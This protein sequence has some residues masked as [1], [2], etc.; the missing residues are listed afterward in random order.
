MAS[1]HVPLFLLA[2]VCCL[3]AALSQNDSSWYYVSEWYCEEEC[4]GG[5][6]SPVR[7]GEPGLWC[8]FTALGY[9]SS[10]N[11]SDT[12]GVM[13]P[14]VGIVM[15]MDSQTNGGV[16]VSP[17]REVGEEDDYLPVE[18]IDVYDTICWILSSTVVNTSEVATETR[19]NMTLCV[20]PVLVSVYDQGQKADLA[21]FSTLNVTYYS[22][23]LDTGDVNVLWDDLVWNGTYEE[24]GVDCEEWRIDIILMVIATF[25]ALFVPFL[26]YWFC[27]P[28]V[29]VRDILPAVPNFPSDTSCV[30]VWWG[31]LIDKLSLALT[32]SY[33]WGSFTYLLAA[34]L[35]VWNR[36]APDFFLEH[37]GF[38]NVF[39]VFAAGLCT[40][41]VF[42]LQPVQLAVLWCAC[43][44]LV[45]DVISAAF[46]HMGYDKSPD[47]PS[48]AAEVECYTNTWGSVGF[49]VSAVMYMWYDYDN[50][51]YTTTLFELGMYGTCSAHM[52]LLCMSSM[53]V[54]SLFQCS[55]CLK[56]SRVAG[57][58]PMIGTKGKTR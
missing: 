28:A 23:M 18:F 39:Y 51:S 19:V 2:A 11:S 48:F 5:Y 33:M 37:E 56:R 35:Y 9:I 4:K 45:T 46:Y 15:Q 57:A 52:S 54:S 55:G 43:C 21:F 6:P 22:T 12:D 49:V 27:P 44:E 47:P 34:V 31:K 38:A 32:D 30:V 14:W 25:Q 58:L 41:H 36:Q 7:W 24:D 10:D 13:V 40:S 3:H 1:G 42:I 17:V 53:L 8:E 29:G 20:Q 16:K 26:I 50:M